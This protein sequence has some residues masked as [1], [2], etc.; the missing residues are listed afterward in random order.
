MC[1]INIATEADAAD[2][3]SIAHSARLGSQA[4]GEAF[5]ISD[6]EERDYKSFAAD[7]KDAVLLVARVDGKCAGFALFYGRRY[8]ETKARENLQGAESAIFSLLSA[9]PGMPF[10]VIKQ[11]AVASEFR[12]KGIGRKLYFKIFEKIQ[13]GDKNGV[14]FFPHRGI[15]LHLYLQ[16]LSPNQKIKSP[17][18]FICRLVFVR[19]CSLS[20]IQVKRASII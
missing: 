18:I 8:A 11:I 9:M 17:K 10:F 20:P 7:G 19:L 2:I 16:Q 5:L 3:F 1:E 12:N 14:R 15:E 4:P 13:S 6:Y